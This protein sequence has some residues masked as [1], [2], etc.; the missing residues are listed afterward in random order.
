[1]IYS[2][3]ILKAGMFML[4][5]RLEIQGIMM[6][7]IPLNYFNHHIMTTTIIEPKM[8]WSCK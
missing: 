8:D 1:M 2:R 4:T 3:V 7:D 6:K 5:I